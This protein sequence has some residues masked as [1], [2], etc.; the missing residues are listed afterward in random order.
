MSA[1][2]CPF[3]HSEDVS[4]SALLDDG[5]AESYRYV[6]CHNCGAQGPYVQGEFQAIQKWNARAGGGV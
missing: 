2:P 3:C 5:D 6:E 4:V 1:D